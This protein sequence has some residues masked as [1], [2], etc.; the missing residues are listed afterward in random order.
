MP[1]CVLIDELHCS[2]PPLLHLAEAG[3]GV[4]PQGLVVVH[5]HRNVI[6]T[7]LSG[8][9]VLLKVEPVIIHGHEAVITASKH[10]SM[11]LVDIVGHHTASTHSQTGH[12]TCGVEN[13]KVFLALE[14][15]L[16]E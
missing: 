10:C 15:H 11:I 5:P 4:E 3:A 1:G 12:I 13:I 16:E 8:L 2:R 7:V 6:D 9:P 14:C